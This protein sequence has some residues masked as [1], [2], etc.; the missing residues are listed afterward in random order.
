MKSFSHVPSLELSNPMRA[1]HVMAFLVLSGIGS[2]A[3]AAQP[4][5]LQGNLQVSADVVTASFRSDTLEL[6]GNVRIEQGPNSIASEHATASDTRSDQSH[7]TFDR[8]VHIQTAEA[9]L[10]SNR[11]TAVFSN[12]TIASARIEGSPATFEQ[13]GVAAEKQVRGRAGVIDYDFRA[14]LVTLSNDVWFT[15]GHDQEISG[16]TVV[17]NVRDESVRVTSEGHTSGRVKGIIRPRPKSSGSTGATTPDTAAH[18]PGAS[19]IGS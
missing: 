3:H 7:W 8:A 6:E 19:E 9:D 5:V 2:L 12:G 14:G 4:L 16:G 13:R 15:H 10:T 11:A 1:E 18:A 17:Y